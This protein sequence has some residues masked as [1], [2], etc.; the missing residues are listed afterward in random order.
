MGVMIGPL[1][2]RPDGAV[3][4][5]RGIQ[6]SELVPRLICRIDGCNPARPRNGYVS[7]SSTSNRAMRG[8]TRGELELSHTREDL[9][10]N[11]VKSE[12]GS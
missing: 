12:A 9:K 10:Q 11:L 8:G 5:D 7:E 4:A 2:L 3:G 1:P 6:G